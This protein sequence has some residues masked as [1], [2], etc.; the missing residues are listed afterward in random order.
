VNITIL[1]IILSHSLV[2]TNFMQLFA[3]RILMNMNSS[4]AFVQISGLFSHLGGTRAW[5]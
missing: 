3:I 4:K 5:R 2:P 1:F